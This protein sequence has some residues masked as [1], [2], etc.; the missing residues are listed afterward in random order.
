MRLKII[1]Y[2]ENNRFLIPINYNY[3][4][5]SAIYKVFS[6]G[7][8][9]F[10]DWL[11]NQG[12]VTKDGKP[13]KLFTFSKLFVK[14]A[15]LHNNALKG[16]GNVTL[17]FSS[18]I[19]KELVESFVN[20][21]LNMRSI[22]VGNQNLGSTFIISGVQVLEEPRFK[23]EA[24]FR[25]LSPTTVSTVKDIDGER[26]IYYY[27][28]GDDG[29]EEAIAKNLKKKYALVHKK[30]YGGKLKVIFDSKYINKSGGSRRLSKLITL[31]EGL[32]DEIKIKGFLC[33]L[34]LEGSS[35]MLQT[36]YNCGI[37]ERTS[38]GFGMLEKAN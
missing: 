9:E 27:R 2:S 19:E 10:S 37:G 30:E 15:S 8:P 20:G 32:S 5:S 3:P 33:P 22:Y 16:K 38:Q 24:N 29:I 6:R 23:S 11:H 4:L 36:A 31:K 14:N 28:L 17:Y 12:Y 35:E 26:K 25:M 1:L 7:S 21:L 13:M 18:P 34:T